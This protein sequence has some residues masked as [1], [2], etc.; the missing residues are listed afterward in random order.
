MEDVSRRKFLAA[1]GSLAAS[2]CATAELDPTEVV[3]DMEG[4]YTDEINTSSTYNDSTYNSTREPEDTE[5][6]GSIHNC[7][8]GDSYETATAVI[9]PEKGYHEM[10]KE[11][12]G[13]FESDGTEYAIRPRY[14]RSEEND[15]DSIYEFDRS[16]EAGVMVYR[17]DTV[18]Q[19]LE[20][21]LGYGEDSDYETLEEHPQAEP[22]F[23]ADMAEGDHADLKDFCIELAE[24]T[25]SEGISEAEFHI[26]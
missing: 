19:F 23:R 17:A 20:G 24:A 9:F 26:G 22:V 15:D 11:D 8:C 4:E 10:L 16:D 6:T 18:E 13:R 25:R 5:E 7:A 1:A 21:T 14:I 12:I 2:G 3:E